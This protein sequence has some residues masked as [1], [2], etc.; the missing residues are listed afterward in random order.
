VTRGAAKPQSA[1][2]CDGKALRT[3]MPALIA[4]IH[5][6]L[7]ERDCESWLA[8][9]KSCYLLVEASLD[10]LDHPIYPRL[11]WNPGATQT[12]EQIGL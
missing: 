8:R 2:R 3:V 4:G 5:V 6:F 10:P 12:F 1:F 7:G 11:L 9:T